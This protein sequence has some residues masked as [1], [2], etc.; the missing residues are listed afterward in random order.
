MIVLFKITS[1]FWKVIFH[2]RI[3]F[4]VSINFHLE[5]FLFSLS[6]ISFWLFLFPFPYSSSIPLRFL[7]GIA[8]YKTKLGALSQLALDQ[9]NQWIDPCLSSLSLSKAFS[10][11]RKIWLFIAPKLINTEK[12]SSFPLYQQACPFPEGG[13]LKHLSE[14]ERVSI[15]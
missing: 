2:L 8:I 14:Y 7:T 10:L 1:S 4:L 5:I 9:A 15:F 12:S 11:L 13:D 3:A 6:L